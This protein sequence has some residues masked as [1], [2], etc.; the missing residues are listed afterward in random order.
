MTW[1]D[2]DAS[3]VA[4]VR[5]LRSGWPDS[6]GRLTTREQINL[7]ALN[8]PVAYVRMILYECKDVV[9]LG[10]SVLIRVD[11]GSVWGSC[12]LIVARTH[13]TPISA[14]GG[15]TI[16]LSQTPVKFNL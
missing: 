1:S 16:G 2:S 10:E 4:D 15:Y 13:N 14:H 7:D 8:R 11:V 3:R 9:E 5:F 12:G 6:E